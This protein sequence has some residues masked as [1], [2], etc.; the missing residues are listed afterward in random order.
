MERAMRRNR[1]R[2][3]GTVYI[4]RAEGVD[5]VKI[6]FTSVQLDR[7]IRDLQTGCP[8]ILTL[9]AAQ[10]GTKADEVTIHDA[11][12]DYRL[13]GEWFDLNGLPVRLLVEGATANG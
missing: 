5:A 8:H 10:A 1:S 2:R 12:R 3:C 9:I 7:R 11:L 13:R 6:G 4:L